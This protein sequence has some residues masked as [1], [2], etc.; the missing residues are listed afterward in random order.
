MA[1]MVRMPDFGTAVNEVR[2]TKWLFDEGASVRRGDLLAE[3]ETDKATMELESIADG[4][5]L[6]RLVGEGS[7][8]ESGQLLAW[9]GAAGESIDAPP[10]PKPAPPE[11]RISPVVVN[12]AARLGVDLN[13]IRGTGAGGVIT[14]EDI[15]G[16]SK[17]KPARSAQD[18]VAR[19]VEQSAAEI[20]HVRV[21]ASID[22]ASVAA[23]KTGKAF[24]DAVFLKAIAMARRKCP[25]PR[26]DGAAIALAVD[27]HGQLHMPVIRNAESRP[28]SDLQAAI[29]SVAQRAASGTWKAEDLGGATIA[30]SNLGMY[31]VDWFEA[32]I[33]P[34]HTAILALA[35]IEDRPAVRAGAI[36]IRPTTTV[37]LAADHRS[38]N[39]RAAAQFLAALK[40][41]VESGEVLSS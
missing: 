8:A 18:A 30:L 29:A 6:R 32:I 15:L 38:V 33:Y 20:P 23:A 9:I 17:G 10:V 4:I 31:P 12:L 11:P 34:G 25:L 39:G 37:V 21:S 35:R 41:L 13:A 1:V 40:D 19:A 3:I 36:E 16:A 7:M 5:L 26:V 2:L 28:L 14:R 22:M 24:Y 27:N